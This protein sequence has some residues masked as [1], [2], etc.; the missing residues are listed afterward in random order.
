[1]PSRH[2]S[3]TTTFISAHST[4]IDHMLTSQSKSGQVAQRRLGKMG[5]RGTKLF[6][7]PE[8]RAR[9][10][11]QAWKSNCVHAGPWE[12]FLCMGPQQ[13]LCMVQ[14]QPIGDDP[15]LLSRPG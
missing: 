1:L 8:R 7:S 13:L 12:Q 11:H 14:Q 6:A 3:A 9:T 5:T 10:V 4:S 2:W 15:V